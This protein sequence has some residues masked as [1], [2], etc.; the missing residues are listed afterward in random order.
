[1]AYPPLVSKAELE[2]AYPGETF[3]ETAIAAISDDIR[4]TAGWHIAPEVTETLLVRSDGE[5][6]MLLPTL[7]VAEI[8]GM[9]RWTGTAW[10]SHWVDVVGGYDARSHSLRRSRGFPAGLYRVE[11]TH[12]FET[13]PPALMEGVRYLLDDKPSGRLVASESLPGH[14]VTFV[15]DS[16][17]QRT[18]SAFTSMGSL[19]AYKLGP[20]P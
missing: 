14:A 18:Y 6:V 9:E 7:K 3:T 8:V 17:A 15:Q 13:L 2:A 1:M 20:R 16:T 10:V 5:N 12:G 4:L 19:G 11:L